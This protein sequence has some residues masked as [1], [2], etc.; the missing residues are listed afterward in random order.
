MADK[1]FSYPA[2]PECKKKVIEAGAGG[3]WRCERCNKTFDDCNHT[4]N[5][6][7]L[8]GDFTSAYYV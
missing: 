8:L 1:G 5:F 3:G 7:V 2:C 6:S 4:Y